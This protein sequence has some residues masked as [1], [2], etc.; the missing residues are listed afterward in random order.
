VSLSVWIV[1][2]RVPGSLATKIVH[3][4]REGRVL[5][6]ALGLVS[7][8]IGGGLFATFGTS[9]VIEDESLQP[10]GSRRRRRGSLHGGPHAVL[11]YLLAHL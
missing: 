9:I 6:S 10:L 11:R 1:L 7:A 3:N 4:A 8:G 2:G 5:D